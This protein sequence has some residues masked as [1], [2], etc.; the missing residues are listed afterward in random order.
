[1]KATIK[2]LILMAI[3]LMLILSSFTFVFAEGPYKVVDNADILSNDEEAFL[4]SYILDIIE[5]HGR[6]LVIYT[7]SIA[8]GRTNMEIAD[9]FYDQENLGIGDDLSG[10]LLFIN[11]DSSQRGWWTTTTGSSMDY[12]DYDNINV[13]DD[14]IYPDMADGNYCNA[15]CT[16]I[17][18]VDQLYETGSLYVRPE[19]DN[20]DYYYEQDHYT[21]YKP[22]LGYAI[23][24]SL[25]IGLFI[26]VAI[27]SVSYAAAK[28]SMKSIAKATRADRYFVNNSFKLTRKEDIFRGTTVIR[29]P[30]ADANDNNH[31]GDHHTTFHSGGSSFSGGH[32]S[33]GGG[34]HGGGGRSF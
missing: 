27:T 32:F 12:F 23:I 33:S 14:A 26:F 30:I 6:D 31:G 34:F 11:F 2:R 10:S 24:N 18:C 17:E 28:K 4:E 9:D 7:D 25:P 5:R 19:D 20:Y 16:Y 1:M 15:F 21:E 13:I 22:T 8:D 29:T 3:A